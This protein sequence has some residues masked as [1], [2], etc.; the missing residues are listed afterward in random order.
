MTVG[1]IPY[2]SCEPFYFAMQRRGIALYDVVP[3]AVAAAMATG[4][5]MPGQ[6]H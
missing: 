4:A 5:T 6:C 1:R 2:L 3:S